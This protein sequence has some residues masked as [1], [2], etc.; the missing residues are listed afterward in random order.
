VTQA[1]SVGPLEGIRVLDFTQ[2]MQ[3]PWATQLFGDMGADVIKVEPPRG[4]WERGYTFDDVWPGGESALFLAMNRSKRSVVIDLKNERG[5]A[6]ALRLAASADILIEN[7]RPGVMERLGLSYEEVRP[8]NPSLVYASATGYGRDGPYAGRPGQDLLIQS[9]SGLASIT[10]SPDGPPVAAG[11]AIADEMGAKTLASAVL[12]ALFHRE[13]TGEGQRVE[14]DLLDVL[15]DCQCQEFSAYL[16]GGGDPRRSHLAHAMSPAPYGIYRTSDGFIAVAMADL[17][18]LGEILDEPALAD[19]ADLRA[20]RERRD[21][22]REILQRT[23]QTR[24]TGDWMSVLGKHDVWCAPVNDYAAV[25]ADPQ[26]RHNG[27]FIEFEHPKAGSVRAT[28]TPIKMDQT[29]ARVQRPPPLLGEH[30]DEVL[31]EAGYSDQELEE[32]HLAGAIA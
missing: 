28:A 25:A 19:L 8:S 5:R 27:T 4:D 3:G 22:A 10:G 16:N 23:L 24:T 2:Y 17:V 31:R 1:N 21:E 26:V 7:A 32:L 18:R 14:I 9:L 20:A 11:T 29:P 6:V 15:I 13:R 30:T 12:L